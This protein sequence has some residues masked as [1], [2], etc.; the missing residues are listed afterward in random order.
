MAALVDSGFTTPAPADG[1]VI[2]DSARVL[3][4]GGTVAVA[5]RSVVVDSTPVLMLGMTEDRE[6]V[7]P[8]GLLTYTLL[9]G[10][11]GAVSSP[12]AAL[13]TIVPQG[14][15]FV[16]ASDGGTVTNGIVTWSL[17]TLSA[18]ASG[19]RQFTVQVGA[20]L[21]NGS[22]LL[23][24]AEI[25][26]TL[27]PQDNARAAESTAVS[28]VGASPLTLSLT[29]TPD[30]VK[31][32]E[33]ITYSYTVTNRGGT[34]LGGL[35]LSTQ[36]PDHTH[37]AASTITGGG[38]CGNGGCNAGNE[39]LWTLGTLAAG[40]SLPPVQIGAKVDS[41][42]TT[43][44][45]MDGTIIINSVRMID[46]LG[47]SAARQAA[48]RVCAIGGTLCDSVV[49]PLV[50]IG[51]VVLSEGNSGP[52]TFSFP[53]SLSFVSTQTVTVFFSTA[54]GSA[55]A[56]SDYVSSSG[57][58]TFIAGE[59]VKNIEVT[60]NGDTVPE[61]NETFFVNLSSATNA[62]ISD[63]HATGTILNDDSVVG[64]V[65]VKCPSDS[66]QNAI[67]N[68]SPGDVIAV[69]GICNENILVRN[70]KQRIAIDGGGTAT[71]NG[72]N[73][74]SPT[75]NVRGKGIVIQG[76]TITGGGDGVLVNRGSN[77]VINSNLIQNTNGNGIEVQQLSFAVIIDNFIESNAEAGIWVDE[78][79]TARI[80]FNL[81]TDAAAG[82]N[83]IQNNGFGV[84]VSGGSSARVVG[85][86][87]QSNSSDGVFVTRDSHADIDSNISMVTGGT[88]L[89][90]G[91]VPRWILAKTS[92]RAYTK[93]RTWP[94]ARTR[95]SVSAA[96]TA[97]SSTGGREL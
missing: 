45:P 32:G 76:L 83:T 66:L 53:V 41:G 2:L 31:P 63:S 35:E 86:A 73:A 75:I 42:F 19:R 28:S 68:A 1:T 4:S 23:S 52:K 15:S 87:I 38:G 60:V 91:K 88:A 17:G 61:L 40:Q 77:A 24:E 29:A 22:M 21:G 3:N 39:I 94:R 6:P 92:A 10:N 36:V 16:S 84:I 8:G 96:P 54:N 85:N 80:G 43:P 71:I 48:T 11:R 97:V 26:D 9:F 56:G 5:G 49:P 37:V 14:A 33:L 72:P 46:N 58:V 62:I 93:C 12:N 57:S 79:S 69:I 34:D 59:T 51:N 95:D 7:E 27:T 64:A 82:P 47:N 55:T 70:E 13:S 89:K 18:G 74:S 25:H 78:N 30:P 65:T 20:G 50:F 67:E 81:D 90:S 44:A